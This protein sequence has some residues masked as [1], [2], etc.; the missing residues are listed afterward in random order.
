MLVQYQLPS[1]PNRVPAIWITRST[2]RRSISGSG[3]SLDHRRLQPQKLPPSRIDWSAN[4]N[5]A[6]TALGCCAE[7]RPQRESA[8]LR[9]LAMKG[10]DAYCPRLR[11][12]RI[13]YGRRLEHR[14]ALFPGYAFVL[15]RLQWSTIGS[16]P[17]VMGLIMNGG[18]PARVPDRIL[19]EIRQREVDGLIELPKPPEMRSGDRV[20]VV[21]GPFTGQL[22]LYAGMRPRARVE[23]LLTLLRSQHGSNCRRTASRRFRRRGG[24]AETGRPCVKR[25]RPL[26]DTPGR[27]L[28]PRALP[29]PIRVR[30]NPYGTGVP[31][32][33][34]R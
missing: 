21:A 9:W 32:S 27:I 31:W 33:T 4:V 23:V 8:A 12:F 6:S 22:D 20:R 14:P 34:V 18:G 16:T 17:G 30:G 2:S 26:A 3:Q 29:R 7:F 25:R 13:R 5:A 19:D 28:A 10:F 24:R 1:T 11:E 15:I